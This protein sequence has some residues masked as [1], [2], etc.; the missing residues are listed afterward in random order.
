MKTVKK[1]QNRSCRRQF[2][3]SAYEAHP[4]LTCV[5]GQVICPHC[6]SVSTASR[7]HIYLADPLRA[8]EY[9][10]DFLEKKVA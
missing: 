3:V 5:P 4:A 2:L 10:I 7:T 1:C 9:E 8:E 6:K